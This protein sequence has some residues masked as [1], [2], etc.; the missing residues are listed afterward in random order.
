MGGWRPRGSILPAEKPRDSQTG[1]LQ[2][3]LIGPLSKNDLFSLVEREGKTFVEWASARFK[4]VSRGPG[5]VAGTG[6]TL[7]WLG[8]L[9][10]YFRIERAGYLVLL[11]PP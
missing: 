4:L 3:K 5:A 1:V 10:G 6:A 9:T 2:E 8:L 7:M 11:H